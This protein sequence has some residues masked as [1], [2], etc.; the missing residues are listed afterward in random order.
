MLNRTSTSTATPFRIAGVK[1]QLL[2]T[3][4]SVSETALGAGWSREVGVN[5]PSRPTLPVTIKAS[6]NIATISRLSG[7]G[8]NLGTMGRMKIRVPG[9]EARTSANQIVRKEDPAGEGTT[10]VNTGRLGNNASTAVGRLLA[11]GHCG[12]ATAAVEAAGGNGTLGRG[13]GGT[14]GVGFGAVTEAV[15]VEGGPP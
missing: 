1:I 2:K 3:S 15:A 13:G 14:G 5:L 10:V 7:Q 11:F 4:M 12:S 6:G 9:G 8:A